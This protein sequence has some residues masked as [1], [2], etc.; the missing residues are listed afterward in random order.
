MC[1]GKVPSAAFQLVLQVGVI[2]ESGQVLVLDM[3]TPVTIVDL[4]KD[5]IRFYG[6]DSDEGLPIVFSGTRPGEKLYEELFTV[7]EGA[8]VTCHERILSA[9]MEKPAEDWHAS[10]SQLTAIADHG[11]YESI[12]FASSAQSPLAM[13]ANSAIGD[14]ASEKCISDLP[15]NWEPFGFLRVARCGHKQMK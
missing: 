9:R 6:L 8:E 3:G 2:R 10:L 12:A 4:A 1:F 7:E 13:L 5:V 14:C 11:N 15:S